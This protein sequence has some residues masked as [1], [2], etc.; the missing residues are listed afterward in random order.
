MLVQWECSD[1]ER[2]SRGIIQTGGVGDMLLVSRFGNKNVAHSFLFV[3]LL[4]LNTALLL[5]CWN[6]W[7][8]LAATTDVKGEHWYSHCESA[9]DRVCMCCLVKLTEWTS[10]LQLGDKWTDDADFLQYILFLYLLFHL[11]ILVSLSS[12][13]YVWILTLRLLSHLSAKGES[14]WAH[15]KYKFIDFLRHI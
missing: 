2:G 6:F 9:C 13:I 4:D 8:F 7:E 5:F 14:F 10:K 12:Y 15:N 11:D 3:G 1:K